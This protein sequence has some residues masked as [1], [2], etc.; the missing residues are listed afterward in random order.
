MAKKNRNE[1]AAGLFVI[2]CTAAIVGVIIWLGSIEFSRRSVYLTAS[3]TSGDI[4]IKKDSLVKLGAVEV[5]RVA[6]VIA[7]DDWQTF[8]FRVVL[9][10]DVDIRQD[11]VIEATPPVLGDMGSL[12]VLDI[13]SM[14]AP[15]ADKEHPSRLHVG[16]N[17]IIR[18]MKRELGYGEAERT[19]FQTALQAISKA[20][21]NLAEV[22]E[23]LKEQLTS[24]NEPNMLG[25]LVQT[26]AWLRETVGT[27]REEIN[28]L[29][30]Q[31][32]PEN[33]QGLLAKTNRSL[34]NVGTI[35]S[36]A[37]E[38]VVNVRPKIELAA[39][40]AAETVKTI[41]TYSKVDLAELLKS[42][43][44]STSEL[45]TVMEN[46]REVS[47]T[48]KE[49][50]TLKRDNIDEMISNLTQVS[51][52]L[53]ATSREVRRHPWKLLNKP[54]KEHIRSQNVQ[55]AAEAFAEGAGQL[56]DA[57]SRLKAL[58][59]LAGKPIPADDP[60]LKQIRLKI[61]DS[62]ERFT[63]AEQALWR[64]LAH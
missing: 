55:N 59:L 51:V 38:L 9:E 45:L 40:G 60:Q 16:S 33:P 10:R 35:T 26:V 21:G 19:A 6:E 25:D 37:A 23:T 56:D 62:F 14:D 12:I 44:A 24:G 64:E 58:A 63:Q 8:T 43:R 50:V 18:D 54:D 1:L 30:H 28:K 15:P 52:N 36:E 27:A 57:V 48:A 41:E 3:L 20:T 17:P 53:K 5:G 4:S 49:V 31:L 13:G 7:S 2:A 22:S 32:D 34:D 61:K 11:A 46:F 47:A 29:K 39:A 42:V